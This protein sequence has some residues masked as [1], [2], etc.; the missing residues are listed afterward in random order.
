MTNRRQ[1]KINE[2]IGK[3]VTGL[4]VDQHINASPIRF[5]IGLQVGNDMINNCIVVYSAPNEIMKDILRLRT[6]SRAWRS[7]SPEAGALS[8]ANTSC[9]TTG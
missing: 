9:S 1:N 6:H 3:I 2:V 7:A 4:T 5:G 8:T